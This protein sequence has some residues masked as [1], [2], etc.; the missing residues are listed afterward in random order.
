MD[1][2]LEEM[3][4]QLEQLMVDADAAALE[5]M[6]AAMQAVG[7]KENDDAP[8]PLLLQDWTERKRPELMKRVAEMIAAATGAGGHPFQPSFADPITGSRSDLT[9]GVDLEA[10]A[11]NS[12]KSVSALQKFL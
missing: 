2:K 11:G 6:K 12:G 7:A 1:K 3:K 8:E 5:K 10:L 9:G 4:I